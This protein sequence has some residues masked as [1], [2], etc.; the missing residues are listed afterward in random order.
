MILAFVHGT[1][2]ASQ[3]IT[4]T[5]AVHSNDMLHV[6]GDQ[7]QWNVH[8]NALQERDWDEKFLKELSPSSPII[9]DEE[10]DSLY[11]LSTLAYDS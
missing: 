6:V 5:D 1:A 9:G 8:A 2:S 10:D 11:S 4:V 7:A 3:K